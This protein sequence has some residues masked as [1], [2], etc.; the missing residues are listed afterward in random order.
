MVKTAS[1]GRGDESGY[2]YVWHVSKTTEVLDGLLRQ[3][4]NSTT[5]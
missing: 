5:K 3:Q 2:F 1:T 4:A